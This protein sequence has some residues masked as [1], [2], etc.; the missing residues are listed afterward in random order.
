MSI[1]P[2]KLTALAIAFFTCVQTYA[3]PVEC[4]LNAS[5]NTKVNSFDE[6]KSTPKLITTEKHRKTKSSSSYFGLF[7]M[8][9]PNITK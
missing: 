5:N 8:L 1:K 9:I 2:I 4:Q 3:A 7:K 6:I